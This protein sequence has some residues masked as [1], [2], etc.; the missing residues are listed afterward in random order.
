ML[1][2]TIA[3]AKMCQKGNYK[4]TEKLREGGVKPTFKYGGPIGAGPM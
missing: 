4:H 1:H 3:G 2:N